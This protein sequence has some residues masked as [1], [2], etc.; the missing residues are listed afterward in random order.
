MIHRVPGVYRTFLTIG[1][2]LDAL[3]ASRASGDGYLGS[4]QHGFMSL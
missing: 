3:D 1:K 4:T 2:A